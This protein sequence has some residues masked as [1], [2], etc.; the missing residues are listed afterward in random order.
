M[1]VGMFMAILDIQIVAS[2]IAEIQAGVAASADE[3]VWVQS[4][5]LIAEIVM[6]PLSGFLSRL[7]STRVLFAVSA[8]GFTL[9]SLACAY[10]TG[11]DTLI[12]FRVVQGF[13]GGAM[14]P[15]MFATA[16]LLFPPA[17]R[18]QVSGLIGLVVTLAPTIGPTLGGYLTSEFSWHWL[19]LVNVVPGFL[20]AAAVWHFVDVD[21]ADWSLLKGFDLLGLLFMAAFLGSLEFVLEEGTRNDWFEDATIRLFAGIA[22]L[23]GIGFFWRSLTRPDP[24]VQLRTFA[25]RT[26]AMGTLYTF[27]V[28]IGL[29]GSVYV[30]PLFLG[31]IRHLNA[32]QIG[33]T[34]IV[35]GIF[36]FITAPIAGTLAG[37]T[38]LRILMAAG[39]SLVA[40]SFFL[41]APVTADWSFWELFVPQAMRGVGIMFCIVPVTNLALG[42]M[43][44][45]LMKSASGLL[46]LTRNLGGAVGLAVINTVFTERRTLHA[47][48]IGEW[49]NLGR[50]QVQGFVDG[51]AARLADSVGGDGTT[52]AVKVLANLV[53]REAAVMTFA[54]IF[55]MMGVV[56]AL[57]AVSLPLV[58][59]P[60]RLAAPV[61]GH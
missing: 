24:I 31:Q 44:P 49:A 6:I 47:E 34:M 10:A 23:A 36:Q 51:I 22:V 28:G 53:H 7:L 18:G 1:I 8:L 12:F 35:T 38:D 11:I 17:K 16:F 13:L 9:S 57:M 46:N 59:R 21:R 42:D 30:M 15:T 29:Y 55:V 50:P 39:G 43:N 61:E 2:S 20:V 60:P 32:L 37:K 14:I 45:G 4:A 19:F 52:Q 3:V 56:F 54:D 40:A 33:E 26:F 48:Q 27:V 58:R 25:N 5:Y 41:M